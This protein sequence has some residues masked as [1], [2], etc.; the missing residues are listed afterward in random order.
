MTL[1]IEAAVVATAAGPISNQAQIAFDSD[2]NGSN[3]A[4]AVSDDPS[5]A[6]ADA[7][8]FVFEGA[9]APPVGVAP[10]VIPALDLRVLLLSA[11]ALGLLGACAVR[12]H[13]L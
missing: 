12:R 7:T 1:R 3:D 13:G 4:D 6:G 8:V 9:A 2:G 10:Q 11:L 5:T